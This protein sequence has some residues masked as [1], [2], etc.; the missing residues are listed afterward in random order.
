MMTALRLN[1]RHFCGA[2][3][4]TLAAGQLSLPGFAE[5]TNAKAEVAQ[6][7]GRDTTAIRPFRIYVPE[8]E[9][10]ELR[11]RPLDY[12]LRLAQMRSETVR[13]KHENALPLIVTHGWPGSITEQ[14]KI[15]RTCVTLMKRLGYARFVAQGGDAGGIITNS[16]AQQAPPELIGM[17]TNFHGTAPLRKKCA[18]AS[19]P[20]AQC[21]SSRDAHSP[22]LRKQ[23][24]QA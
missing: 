14:L 4:A 22:G 19:G 16:M 3:T 9:L 8:A 15:A 5:R 6:Q 13:F 12:G 10:T 21:E 23:L 18:P 20:S 11:R 24:G 2:V 1:R 17:H 7:T